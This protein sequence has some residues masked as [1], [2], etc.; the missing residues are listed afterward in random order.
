MSNYDTLNTLQLRDSVGF[1]T[2][3]S[4]LISTT[5]RDWLQSNM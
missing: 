5:A 1:G 2:N 4:P 3:L